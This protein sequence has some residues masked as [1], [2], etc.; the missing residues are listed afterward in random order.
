MGA[1]TGCDERAASAPLASTAPSPDK[2]ALET[3]VAQCTQDMVR[4]TC[5]VMDNAAGSS[6]V[7]DDATVFVAGVG[8]IDAKI[9]NQLRANGQAMCETVR[10][11]CM[12]EWS[13]AACKTARAL[14]P[15]QS[16]A[17]S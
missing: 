13:G 17:G 1:L 6:A 15:V 10:Q 2:Q 9:Y 8:A 14:Y 11:S 5:R 4:Q 12:S 16:G 7:A 3:L